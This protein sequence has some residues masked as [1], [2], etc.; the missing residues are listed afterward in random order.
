M[1]RD[2]GPA[3]VSLCRDAVGWLDQM[4]LTASDKRELFV[5]AWV[6]VGLLVGCKPERP[7]MPRVWTSAAVGRAVGEGEGHDP[8]AAKIGDYEVRLSEV[9]KYY[10]E[11]P[12]HVRLRHQSPQGRREFLEAF[13]QFL[14]LTW[15]AR[16]GGLDRD[17]VVVDAL[18]SAL[19]S[20]HLRERVDAMVTTE[21]APQE[22][23]HSYYEQNRHEFIR[24][25]Q[26]EVRQVVV[27]DADLA[28]RVAFRARKR[29]S[30]P[31]ADPIE[32][33]SRL[34]SKYSEDE[35]TREASGV[36]GRFPWV[37]PGHPPLPPVVADMATR[38]QSLFEVAGPIASPEGHHILFVSR[39]FPAFE[40]AFEKARVAIV[41][42]WMERERARLRREYVEAVLARAKV[43]VDETVVADVIRRLSRS[44]AEVK[45]P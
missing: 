41:E 9:R 19:V 36:I 18:K 37:D 24:P 34:V 21:N 31:G 35:R 2:F 3:I 39:V 11:M 45:G 27:R 10:E 33:F 7:E 6:L 8:V 13:V 12:V 4:D 40:Q 43:E 1:Q 22:W 28:R 25:E 5:L 17:P 23:L 44:T 42:R 16:E 14:A 32:E 30:Q 26:R 15:I 20:R 29:A 38:M